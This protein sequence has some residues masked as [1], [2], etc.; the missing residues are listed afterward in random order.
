MAIWLSALSRKIANG[1]LNVQ[2]AGSL[3]GAPGTVRALYKP[4]GHSA[5]IHQQRTI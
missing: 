4:A 3:L 2:D 1:K 5:R